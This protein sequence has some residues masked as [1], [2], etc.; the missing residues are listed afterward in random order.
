MRMQQ[1]SINSYTISTKYEKIREKTM[2][3]HYLVSENPLGYVYMN[4]AVKNAQMVCVNYL[5]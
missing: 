1:S 4:F 3:V 5:T 2:C